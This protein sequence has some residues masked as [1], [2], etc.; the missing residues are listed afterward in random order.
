MTKALPKGYVLLSGE[1]CDACVSLKRKLSELNISFIEIDVVKERIP[2]RSIPQ[3]YFDGRVLFLGNPDIS[4]I[5]RLIPR[6]A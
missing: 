2:V 3:L 5:K 4:E 6:S 1:N